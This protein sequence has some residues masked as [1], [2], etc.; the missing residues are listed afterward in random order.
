[1]VCKGEREGEAE[2]ASMCE[3]YHLLFRFMTKHAINVK[4]FHI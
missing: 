3:K 2:W 4:N 1:M